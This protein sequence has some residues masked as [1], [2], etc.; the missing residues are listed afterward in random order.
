MKA[1]IRADQGRPLHCLIIAAALAVPAAAWAQQPSTTAEAAATELHVLPVRGNVFMVRAG[2]KLRVRR[3]TASCLVEAGGGDGRK[4]I[5]A[6]AETDVQC[7][8]PAR[9]TT[10][11]G[12]VLCAGTL[13]PAHT[14]G[15]AAPPTPPS[16]HREGDEAD[17][18]I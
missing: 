5:E 9:L 11:W 7:R 14:V 2:T 13:G 4:V 18:W 12:P 15:F 17:A 8:G 10:S 16:S 1:R 6:V 3:S